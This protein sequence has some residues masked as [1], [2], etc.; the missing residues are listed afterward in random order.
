MPLTNLQF[1]YNEMSFMLVR[2][3]Q[4]V[5]ALEF[6]PEVAPDSMIPPGYNDSPGSDGA[7][8]VWIGN[9]LTA[10]VKVCFLLLL[11]S[12]QFRTF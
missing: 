9:H 1:A 12:T 8:R 3:L 6:T 11:T 2:L 10:F 4:Q 7:D 5:T